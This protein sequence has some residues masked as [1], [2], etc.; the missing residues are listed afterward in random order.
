MEQQM[1]IIVIASIILVTTSAPANARAVSPSAAKTFRSSWGKAGVSFADYRADAIACGEEASAMDLAGSDPARALAAASRLMESEPNAAP[2]AVRDSTQAP[3]AAIDSLALAGAA[4][5]AQQMVGPDRQ[6]AKAGDLMRT[7][8]ERCLAGRGYHAFKLT[9]EQRKALSK[10]PV[11]SD[12][13]HAFL[14]RL[15]SDPDVLSRQGID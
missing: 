15:G 10:L 7:R 8:L 13:R 4:P 14:H 5:S 9:G 3:G 6:I 2:A 11:G 12:A 1:R